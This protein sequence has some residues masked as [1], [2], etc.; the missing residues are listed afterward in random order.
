[1]RNAAAQSSGIEQV[2][3]PD[4]LIRPIYGEDYDVHWQGVDWRGKRVLDVGADV[5][6]TAA[7][8]LSKGAVQV[9][10]VEG[11]GDYFKLLE[12]NAR[13][14]SRI[15]PI[16]M[17]V[18]S[19][20]MIEQLIYASVPDVVKMD[21]E[22]CER[23]LVQVRDEMFSSVPEYLIEVHRDRQLLQEISQKMLHNGYTVLRYDYGYG[24]PVIVG[25]RLNSQAALEWMRR[26]L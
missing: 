9:V 20:A 15:V 16:F 2:Q 11:N 14:D 6:S 24:T 22:G 12:A 19:V 10:A 8:F 23:F 17:R 1:M 4:T 26:N 18:S 5:G 25:R 21:C 3:D 13:K 7:Y